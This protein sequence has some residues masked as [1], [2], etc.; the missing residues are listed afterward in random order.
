MINLSRKVL[1]LDWDKRSLRL[2]VARVRRGRMVLEDAH[3][4]RLPNGVDAD[5]PEAL[6]D[7]IRQML[8]R[9]RLRH[10]WAVV[11]VPRERA[12]INRVTL[13]PTPTAEVAG[14]VRFQAMKELPFPLE[15][16]AADYVITDRDENG[17][18]T[19]VLL[20]AV[21]LETLNRVRET[22]LA[23]GLQPAR[24]GLR[25]YANLISVRRV[26][27]EVERDV[28]L[29]D[30]GP[31]AT[32]IDVICGD[33]LAFARSANVMVPL[34]RGEVLAPADSRVTSL[35]E[36]V[37]LEVS[38]EAVEAAVD[39][40]LVEVTRT[41]Q[42][43]RASEPNAAI[44]KAVVAGGTGIETQFADALQRRLG[45]PVTL[46]DPTDPLGVD[47]EDAKK[48]RSFS[49]ALGLAAGLARE[50]LL[51]LDF[52][53]PKRP[54]SSH[55]T[56]K[57]RARVG[58]IAA[59]VLLA[60]GVGVY[61]KLY[62]DYSQTLKG[63]RKVNKELRKQVEKKHEVMNQIDQADEWAHE[64]VWPDR[65]LDITRAAIEPG[66]DTLVQAIT[67]ESRSRAPGIT[68]RNL[69]ASDWEVALN[70]VQQLNEVEHDGR[71]Q[72]DAT[73][74]AWT[75]MPGAEKFQGKVDIRVELPELREY[76]K[77]SKQ[78]ERARKDRKS[79]INKL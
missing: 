28:L 57:R 7:F 35:A 30:V 12:V 58:V 13:P 15:T 55:E 11:D 1:C 25:P 66:K 37:D 18:A 54:V 32:E 72:F 8:R 50:G 68:L 69:Y 10:K 47:P 41:L 45:L 20:A 48:L 26:A 44:A 64:A 61:G 3:S 4:H 5:D 33:A 76:I 60:G 51:A 40:L 39:E 71:P 16:A 56:L 6:G 78:R 23:A 22:C 67:L 63:V 2:V 34:P 52:L 75:P 49:A 19:A 74:Q 21:T 77:N 42:A 9:H 73:Q 24:I 36:V 70:F 38:D 53:N 65:L 79:W 59:G 46:F 17:L 14:A 31:G 29:V 62:W 43:Y 27:D